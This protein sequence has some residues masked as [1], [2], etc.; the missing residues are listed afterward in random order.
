MNKNGRVVQ[1]KKLLRQG[2]SHAGSGASGNK[3]D[4]MIFSGFH[5]LVFQVNGIN[6][7]IRGNG[8]SGAL[9]N[10]QMALCPFK[11]VARREHA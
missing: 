8:R 5:A 1:R 3:D 6:N 9:S 4:S 2:A 10:H 11:T 7:F